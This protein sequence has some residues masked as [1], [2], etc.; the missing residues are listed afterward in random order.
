MGTATSHRVSPA[1][2]P[3]GE[4]HD[5]PVFVCQQ[6][7]F[8]FDPR[9]YFPLDP[10]EA[11]A[12]FSAGVELNPRRGRVALPPCRKRDTLLDQPPL[13]LKLSQAEAEHLIA[14]TIGAADVLAATD[15]GPIGQDKASNQD[16]ALAATI[17]A[18]HH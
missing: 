2:R 17:R 5:W 13:G 18:S 6:G 3:E 7:A 8:L 15:V 14:D 11:K 10:D 9:A 4:Q 12:E 1:V 16:F